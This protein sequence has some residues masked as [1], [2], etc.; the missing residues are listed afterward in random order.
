MIGMIGMIPTHVPWGER[1]YRCARTRR[2]LGFFCASLEM[3]SNIL[4]ATSLEMTAAVTET[5]LTWNVNDSRNTMKVLYII[6]V[7]NTIKNTIIQ[8]FLTILIFAL[9]ITIGTA[10]YI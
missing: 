4:V 1:T 2:V 8:V 6:H 5:L 10:G 9:N 3:Y 7:V